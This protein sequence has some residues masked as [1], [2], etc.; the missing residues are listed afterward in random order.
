MNN[1]GFSSKRNWLR[2]GSRLAVTLI[3]VGLL[4][5]FLYENKSISFASI[6]LSLVKFGPLC[7]TGVLVCAVTQ[8]LFMVLRLWVLFPKEV[9][10]SLFG[11]AH[12]VSY[13]QLVNTFLPARAGDVLKAVIANKESRNQTHSLMTSAGVILADKIVDLG[14]MI[15]LV[16]ISGA[17]FIP[18]MHAE[19]VI[20]PRNVSAFIALLLALAGVLVWMRHRGIGSKYQWLVHF[21]QGFTSLVRPRMLIT[22]LLLGI[23]AW[24]CEALALQ[25]LCGFQGIVLTFN[26]VIF[27]LF[28]LN[29]AIAVPVSLAN[30]G[31]FEAGV[32]FGLRAFGVPVAQ[33]IAIGSVQHSSQFVGIIAWAAGI[34][35][36]KKMR[37][38]Q[39]P[40][41]QATKHV[42]TVGPLTR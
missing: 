26:R 35:I 41:A 36:R 16:L 10:L 40:A 9:N 33:A 2:H 1:T 39:D 29:A 34:A 19:K 32:V 30:L 37:K 24:T 25:L 11:A 15:F 23:C 17:I 42:T 38:P 28:V 14:A 31:T 3:V 13:G 20:S 27:L 6:R 21:E 18:E 12:A 22:A 8:I 5:A 4:G 7:I